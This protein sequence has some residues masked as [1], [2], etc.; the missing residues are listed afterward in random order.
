V[1]R[2]ER[3]LAIHIVSIHSA[4]R[5]YI[6]SKLYYELG[7]VGNNIKNSKPK[8]I[9]QTVIFEKPRGQEVIDLTIQVS[10]FS[11]IRSG[12]IVRDVM[13]GDADILIK[14]LNVSHSVEIVILTT[15]F[16]TSFLLLSL[17]ICVNR[18]K[19]L[20]YVSLIVFNFTLL[21]TTGMGGKLLHH[22]IDLSYEMNT[23]IVNISVILISILFLLLI[24]NQFSEK[25]RM[26]IVWLIRIQLIVLSACLIIPIWEIHYLYY[27][28]VAFLTISFLFMFVI[29]NRRIE[30]G[31]VVQILFLLSLVSLS[32][33]L[34]VWFY[35]YFTGDVYI[36]YPFDLMISLFCLI[37]TWLKH[38]QG[39]YKKMEEINHDLIDAIESKNN[40]LS[41]VAVKLRKPI[42][43][44]DNLLSSMMQGEIFVK[45]KN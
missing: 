13:F 21:F 37:F 9:P 1:P 41:R 38:Y 27:F 12:G 29:T 43:E 33:H 32:M 40:F 35:S 39:L 25:N 23:R 20:L 45:M 7:S 3:R 11:D 44:M 28:L 42:K 6:D 26:K 4:S 2:E 36:F 30:R 15:L 17:F 24:I 10:N 18:T 34:V 14:N 5:V 31:S 16:L 22:W 8:N 19:E